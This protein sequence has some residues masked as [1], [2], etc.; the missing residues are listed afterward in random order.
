MQKPVFELVMKCQHLRILA[1][2]AIDFW[3]Y[4]TVGPFQQTHLQKHVVTAGRQTSQYKFLPKRTQTIKE[5][6]T[7]SKNTNLKEAAAKRTCARKRGVWKNEGR[8]RKKHQSKSFE[9]A[10]KN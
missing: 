7:C 10:K 9:S 2:D 3:L 1:H 5:I 4:L 6:T 8:K